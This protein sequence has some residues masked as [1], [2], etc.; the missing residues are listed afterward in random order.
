MISM[1]FEEMKKI[2]DDQNQRPLYAIDEDALRRNIHSKSRKAS[3]SSSFTEITLIIISVLVFA[4]AIIR[5]W[6][7]SNPWAYPPVIALLLTSVYIYWG[8]VRR[9]KKEQQFDRTMMGELDHTIFNLDY[10]I[11]RAR[12]F[13]LWYL[14][15]L[16]IPTFLNMY[17]N[18][19]PVNKWIIV[20]CA[21][22][23]SYLVTRW[24][25]IKFQ[26]PRKKNLENLRA[27][28]QADDW[29]E[30]DEDELISKNEW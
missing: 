18:E 19:A 30:N 27:K 11:K 25:L 24:G 7:E 9:M 2:W 16:V 8:R 17:I 26:K 10:E 6:N 20:S 29:S 5:N 13:P 3:F 22:V 12:T 14:A 15:P 23:L 1:D 4:I 21:F 28:I